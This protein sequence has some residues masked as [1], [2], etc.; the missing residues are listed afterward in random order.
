MD[1]AAETLARAAEGDQGAFAEIVRGH[2]A[3]VYSLACRFLRDAALAEELAQEVFLDLYRHLATIES[4]EHLR[5][6]LR[7]VTSHRCIDEGRRRQRRPE[8]T[9]DEMPELGAMPPQRDPIMAL[10][11]QRLVAALP[12]K[13]RLV[14]TLRYQEDLEPAEIA[15]VLDMPVNTVKSHLRRSLT[16]LREKVT[17]CLGEVEV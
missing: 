15:R 1:L 14:V 5:F 7:R 9:V 17:R 8:L 11:L 12:D 4:P 2:Q 16:L 10:T 6:W 3:M 13:P